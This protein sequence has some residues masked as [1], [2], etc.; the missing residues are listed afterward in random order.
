MPPDSGVNMAVP[1][2]VSNRISAGLKRFQPV[3]AAAKARDVNESD[4]VVVITDMLQEIF[5]YDKYAEITSEHAIRGTYC[6]LAIKGPDAKPQLLLEAKAIGVELKDAHVKQAIDYAANQ[7]T[8]WV[9]LTNGIL[10]RVYKVVFAK[11]IDQELVVELDLEKLNPKAEDDL[12]KLWLLSKEGWH[13]EGLADY[14]MQ[15]RAL[16]RFFLGA[17]LLSDAVVEVVR[18]ELRR[19]S[20]GVKITTDE[21]A[22][23]LRH[24]VIKRDVLEGEKSDEARKTVNRAATRALKARSKAAVASEAT[25]QDDAAPPASDPVGL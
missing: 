8:D 24:E 20:P 25:P 4:T 2:K 6:D 10:W 15:R 13:K 9:V 14:H 3:L 12:E 22:N 19:I 11:P 23:V 18:R 5:G 1:Q 16:S 21:I 17:V 7:G